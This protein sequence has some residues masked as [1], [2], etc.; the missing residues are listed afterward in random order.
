MLEYRFYSVLCQMQR[1][2]P[3]TIVKCTEITS[4]EVNIAE[5]RIRRPPIVTVDPEY[6]A[7]L[8]WPGLAY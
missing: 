7:L 4:K 1:Y 3:S 8:V 2:T 5:I 6:F